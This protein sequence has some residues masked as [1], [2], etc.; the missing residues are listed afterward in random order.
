MNLQALVQY[1]RDLRHLFS[2]TTDDGIAIDPFD[3]YESRYLEDDNDTFQLFVSGQWR[4]IEG[5]DFEPVE[6]QL[7]L[8]EI[9]KGFQIWNDNGAICVNEISRVINNLYYVATDDSKMTGRR[10][11]NKGDNT[12]ECAR[13]YIIWR[14]SIKK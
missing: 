14:N 4:S 12:V 6:T 8:I 3:V 11:F 13:E 1:R 2:V 10:I 7:K 9:Y 5:I